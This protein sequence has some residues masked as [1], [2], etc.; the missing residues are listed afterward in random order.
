MKKKI[1]IWITTVLLICS[2]I[3]TTVISSNTNIAR[4]EGGKQGE[5]LTT[6]TKVQKNAVKKETQ[7]KNTEATEKK[8]S[9]KVDNTAKTNKKADNTADLGV[10]AKGTTNI[11]SEK[12]GETENISDNIIKS[13]AR[14]AA[15]HNDVITKMYIKSYDGGTI[16]NNTV[17]MWRTFRVYAEFSLPNNKVKKDDTTTI[18]LPEQLTFGGSAIKFEV[19]DA[20]GNLV[21]NAVIDPN[22]KT[23]TLTY[24]DYPEK[25]SDVKGELFFYAR[26]DETRVKEEKNI[27]L[28]FTISNDVTISAGTLHYKGPN[29]KYHSIIEKV[30]WQDKDN[31]SL[32]HYSIAINESEEDLKGV[33]VQDRLD[34]NTYGVKMLQDTVRIYKV[35]WYWDNGHWK[36]KDDKDV[37]N[38]YKAK[39]K[40][41]P[42]QKGF[43]LELGDIGKEGYYIKYDIKADYTPSDGE[44]FKNKA[45]L[46]YNGKINTDAEFT[47]NYLAAGGK[48]EGYVYSIN[49]LKKDKDGGKALKGAEFQVTRDATGQVIGKFTTDADGKI[50]IK[51]LLKDNYTIKETKAPDGYK[52]DPTEIKIGPS[53]FG[54]DKSVTKEVLNEKAKIKICGT[55]TW[56]DNNNQD[57]KR[58]T[59]IKVKLLADGKEVDSKEVTEKDGWKYSFDNLDKY[60]KDGKEIKYTVDEEVVEFY[61][62]TVDGFNLTNKHVPEKTKVEGLKTWNDNNNQDGKR[63]TKIKVKLLADGKEVASKE[64]TEKDGWK[65]SFDNLDKYKDGKE[66]KY[67]IDEEVVAGYTKEINGYNLK[68]NYTP[69]IVNIAGTK[70]WDDNN[71]QDGKRPSKIKVILNKTVDGNTSKVAEKEVTK[72]NWNYEFKNLPKYENGKEVKYTIDEEDVAGYTK[73]INGYNLTNK[74]LPPPPTPPLPKTGLTDSGLGNL[75]IA[76]LA[77]ALFIVGRKKNLR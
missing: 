21:A 36:H 70:T 60:N 47:L 7:G 15:I 71:N 18:K 3:L 44:I 2:T 10:S 37:T 34:D 74:L 67:T 72:D 39:I 46:K 62:K 55:K 40:W 30:G 38:N 25:H 76:L 14:N 5:N 42:D 31:K 17:E 22:T 4:A 52:L 41:D 69:E 20:D 54:S 66:I 57:G 16:P 32:F 53:D 12:R 8:V 51:G 9:D 65:Y 48:A 6:S 58:P 50:S 19:K 49:L 27:D 29:P 56:D 26:V 73:E 75:G 35:K 1:F 64:V 28:K 59:K 68:N 45:T 13:L 61:E 43:S 23:I 24:T 11:V 63:P 77:A 33:R